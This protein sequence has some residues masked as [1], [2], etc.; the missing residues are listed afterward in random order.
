MHTGLHIRVL[1]LL[2]GVRTSAV[3]RVTLNAPPPLH[4]QVETPS[5]HGL[6]PIPAVRMYSLIAVE[7]ALTRSGHTTLLL[8]TKR[9]RVTSQANSA[10]AFQPLVTTR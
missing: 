6:F 8:K 2:P 5:V 10:Q 9:S 7:M 3:T 4:R 1:A